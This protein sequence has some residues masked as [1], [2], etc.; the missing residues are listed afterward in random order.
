MHEHRVLQLGVQGVLLL[1]VPEPAGFKAQVRIHRFA[2]VVGV[3]GR[4]EA[5][6]GIAQLV[7]MLDQA[8]GAREIHLGEGG[9]RRHQR[10]AVGGEHLVFGAA[11]A[12][13]GIHRK[14]AHT[15]VQRVDEGGDRAVGLKIG[16]L[17]PVEP[18]FVYNEDHIGRRAVRGGEGGFHFLRHLFHLLL[19]VAGRR[20]DEQLFQT[21]HHRFQIAL[22]VA[23]LLPAP[24]VQ[25]ELFGDQRAGAE[26]PQPQ[27]GG[28]SAAQPCRQRRLPAPPRAGMAQCQED[29][30]LADEQHHD[31][32]HLIG[33]LQR[34]VAQHIGRRA[35]RHQI[36]GHQ[37][38]AAEKQV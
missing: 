31:G 4:M 1:P 18:A 22:V 8:V 20:L 3:A 33:E 19:A 5:D 29:L 12:E 38:K 23:V 37:R 28:R 7:Q 14:A 36:V 26:Q 30:Q 9:E 10:G 13:V 34:V 27:N 11:G 15:V 2:I 16:E 21:Q 24:L 35:D 6:A 32:Q 17:V 25:M